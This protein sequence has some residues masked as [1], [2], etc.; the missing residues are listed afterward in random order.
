MVKPFDGFIL[1]VVI[2]SN[3]DTQHN[4][5]YLSSESNHVKLTN[6][7]VSHLLII[8]LIIVRL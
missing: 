8:M 6:G 7:K 2:I 4:V 5:W 1:N 3:M